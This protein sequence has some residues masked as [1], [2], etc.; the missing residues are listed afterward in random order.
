MVGDRFNEISSSEVIGQ[1]HNLKQ[2]GSVQEYVDKFEELM[3]IIRRD[4]PSLTE[5]YFISNFVS[6]LKDY[7]QHHLQCHDYY[8]G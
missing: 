8:S 2:A 1:F 3:G 6:G 5:H 4:N 7:I